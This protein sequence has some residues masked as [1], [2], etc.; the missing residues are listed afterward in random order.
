MMHWARA[1]EHAHSHQFGNFQY[2]SLVYLCRNFGDYF[3]NIQAMPHLAQNTDD[4][5]GGVNDA[6]PAN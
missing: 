1:S 3:V 6:T 4:A 2:S 5:T